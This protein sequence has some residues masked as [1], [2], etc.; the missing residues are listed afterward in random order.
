MLMLASAAI[1]GWYMVMGQ[2]VLSDVSSRSGTLYIITGMAIT[3]A[4][5]RLFTGE[6]IGSISVSGWTAIVALGLTT[7]LSR[8]AMF[9]SLQKLGSVQT[10]IISLT[11]LAVSLAMAFVFLGDRL[12]FVQWVGA[13]MVMGGGVLA[14]LDV[15][16][17]A[18]PAPSF[19]P[20]DS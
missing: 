7:A 16:R 3:V 18:G 14:R 20:M 12:T 5:A 8:M 1:N 10:A 13:I 2:W 4:I 9:F 17:G 11:E 19:N 15:E 6:A